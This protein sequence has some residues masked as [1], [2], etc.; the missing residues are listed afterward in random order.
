LGATIAIFLPAFVFVAASG[1]IVWWMRR[2]AI[3]GSFLSGVNAASV[4]LMAAVTFQLGRAAL[5][6]LTTVFLALAGAAISLRHRVNSAWL[7][8]GGMIGGVLAQT[9]LR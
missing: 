5:V 1:P 3:A 6:D 2:S 9:I 8:I 4:S 7:V